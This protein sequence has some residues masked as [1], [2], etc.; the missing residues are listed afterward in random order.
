MLAGLEPFGN[1]NISLWYGL[2]HCQDWI[3]VDSGF[4]LVKPCPVPIESQFFLFIFS[5][6]FSCSLYAQEPANLWGEV[7]LLPNFQCFTL[8]LRQ[9]GI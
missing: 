1:V 5:Y 6:I 7:A 3:L 4:I 9:R 2:K 8:S